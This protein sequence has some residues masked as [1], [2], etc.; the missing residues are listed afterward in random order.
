MRG[1]G[2]R[3][4]LGFPSSLSAT[5]ATAV[6]AAADHGLAITPD[7]EVVTWGDGDA[8]LPDVPASL[9]DE[10]VTAVA[11]GDHHDLA[12]TSDGKV[13]AWGDDQ[14]GQTDVPASLDG[15]TV[16]AIAAGG[17]HNLALTS[18]GKVTAWGL[19]LSG[20]TDVPASLDGSTVTAIS[21]G[22]EHSLALTADGKVTAWGANSFGQAEVPASLEGRT[23]TAVSGGGLHSLALTSDGAVTAWGYAGSGQT[24]VPA[25]LDGRTV[26]A[27][28]AGLQHSLALTSDG[29]VVA[30]GADALGQADVPAELDG[31]TVTAIAAGSFIS[32][33]LTRGVL[34]MVTSSPFDQTIEVGEETTLTAAATGNPVPTVQWQRAPEGGGFE[35]L[36]GATGTSYTFTP[37]VADDHAMYRAVFTNPYG[38][39]TSFEA[40]LAV[41]DLPTATDLEVTAGFESA[42]PVTLATTID[43]GEVL[44]YSIVTPPAHGTLSG[45]APELTYTPEPGYSGG[46]SFT[47]QTADATGTSAPATVSI[48]VANKP[49]A[50]PTAKDLEVEAGFASTTAVT[51]PGTDPDGDPLTYAVV[52]GPAHGTLSDDAPALTYTPDDEYSGADSFTYRVNDGTQDSATASVRLK[53]AA[54]PCTPTAPERDFTVNA[55]QRVTDAAVRTPKFTTAKPGELL[56]AYVAADGSTAHPQSVTGVRGGDLAWSL[57]R[58]ESTAQGTSEIWQAYAAK[59]VRSTRVEVDLAAEGHNV[60]V[61]VAGFSH[62]RPT[63]GT[64][65]Q[66]SGTSSAPQVSLTPR[67]AG[68]VVWAVGHVA[69]SRYDPTPVSGQKV[70]HDKTFRSPRTGSWTQRTRRTSEAGVDVTVQDKAEAGSWGYVA[71]EIQG[72]CR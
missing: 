52:A 70:V 65:A 37:V 16:T 64:S 57:V 4:H 35:D 17:N 7:G 42:T 14:Y 36:A 34:P 38:S 1:W 9:A 5:G 43:D 46:D 47:Y 3:E 25:S 20:Q 33:A 45:N 28:A 61:T 11:A 24:A 69:G 71:A 44:T 18:D 13:T 10:T 29:Q 23:V 15:S 30:W 2:N 67:A 6:A 21:A 31:R 50:A 56:V 26:T 66:A 72:T 60:T 27:I 22:Q 19:D 63:V 58:R 51:L 59:K 55:D 39:D 40:W 41:N 49:N 12:L 48:T 8:G 68:S 54:R 53:V 62:A 32:V